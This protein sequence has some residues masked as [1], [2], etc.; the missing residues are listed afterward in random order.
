MALSVIQEDQ[1]DL[2]DNLAD[3]IANDLVLDKI[4]QYTLHGWPNKVPEDC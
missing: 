1:V 2:R 4:R 3:A